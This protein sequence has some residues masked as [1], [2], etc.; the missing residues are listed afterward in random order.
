MRPVKAAMRQLVDEYFEAT[1]RL[2]RLTG[3]ATE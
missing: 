1:E 2:Q 3:D